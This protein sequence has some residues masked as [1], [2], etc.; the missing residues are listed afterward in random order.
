MDE[1]ELW[2]ECPKANCGSIFDGD[3]SRCPACGTENPMELYLTIKEV[4]KRVWPDILKIWTLRPSKFDEPIAEILR[5]MLL[6]A[7]LQTL[8]ERERALAT[9]TYKRDC[10]GH[11]AQLF[12]LVNS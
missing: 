4:V 9:G 10:V 12:S 3:T 2:H 6:R 7:L 8:R 11:S 1:Q 5:E